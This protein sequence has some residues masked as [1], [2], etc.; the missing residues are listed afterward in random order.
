M[1]VAISRVHTLLAKWA[2]AL[3][4]IPILTGVLLLVSVGLLGMSAPFVLGALA[5]HVICRHRHRRGHAGPVRCAGLS[6]PAHRHAAVHL[7]RVGVV[8]WRRIPLQALPGG[9][10][11]VA[12]FEPLRQVLDGVRSILYFGASGAAGLTRGLAPHRH[13]PGL[14]A[15]RR[16]RRDDVVRPEWQASPPTRE[17]LP[18]SRSPP[19][20]TRA[21]A[22]RSRVA[23]RPLPTAPHPAD[24]PNEPIR[25]RA[26]RPLTSR[27]RGP[28]RVSNTPSPWST[29]AKGATS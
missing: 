7:P 13:R 17:S 12:N 11:F 22:H 20:R 5:L 9:L 16:N 27:A 3:V 19:P 21:A 26:A 14:L 18:T 28:D 2:I 29:R 24:L 8:R 10:R 4:L 25:L 15:P 23:R 1:P 6:G